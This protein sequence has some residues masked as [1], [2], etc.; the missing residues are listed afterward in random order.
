MQVIE[1]R[2]ILFIP[3]LSTMRRKRTMVTLVL[4]ILWATPLL[5]DTV[6]WD[7]IGYLNYNYPTA[8]ASGGFLF[9]DVTRAFSRY[10]F[11]PAHLSQ[12]LWG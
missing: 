5:A 4:A 1:S 10:Q 9:D 2:P 12:H 11:K 8:T 6:R 3:E 7:V